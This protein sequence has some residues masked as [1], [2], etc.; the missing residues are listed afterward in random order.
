VSSQLSL[1]FVESNDAFDVSA[2]IQNTNLSRWEARTGF[3]LA[4]CLIF[5]PEHRLNARSFKDFPAPAMRPDFNYC[6]Q[7]GQ[8]LVDVIASM[9]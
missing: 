3:G 7:D 8:R 1:C 6:H 2:A 5:L 9:E 4:D